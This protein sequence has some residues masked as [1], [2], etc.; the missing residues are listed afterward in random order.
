MKA[1]GLALALTIGTWSVAAACPVTSDAERLL[2]AGQVQLAW[3][4]EP[5]PITVGRPFELRVSVCPEEARLV[6]VDAMM[7]SHRHGM[8]YRPSI[9]STGPGR[10][11]VQGM[12]WHM[13]GHWQMRFD[14]EAGGTMHVLRQDVELK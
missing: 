3:Q 10:W 5:V 2:R 6:R 7:P 9:A 12:L 13:S 11:Q 8:N 1:D 14:V 4:A